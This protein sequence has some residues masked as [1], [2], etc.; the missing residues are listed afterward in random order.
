M[1]NPTYS[2]ETNNVNNGLGKLSYFVYNLCEIKGVTEIM[3]C[4]C[5]LFLGSKHVAID[6]SKNKNRN[7]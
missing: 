1:K 5:L 6:I 7:I 3:Q 2:S 4:F